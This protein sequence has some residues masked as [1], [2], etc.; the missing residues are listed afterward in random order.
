MGVSFSGS[1]GVNL[2]RMITLYRGLGLELKG[3]R[4]T[5]KAPTCYSIIRREYGLKGN[6]QRV[7]DQFEV[8]LE[9]A[10]AEATVKK[11]GGFVEVS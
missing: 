7:L 3:M 2:Y 5:R 9:E 8:L 10:K 1:R 6:K 4:L 11:E